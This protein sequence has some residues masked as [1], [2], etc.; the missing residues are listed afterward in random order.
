MT[1]S[2]APLC[3]GEVPSYIRGRRVRGY[4]ARHL[5]LSLPTNLPAPVVTMTPGRP[6]FRDINGWQ[7]S[8][9]VWNRQPK[10]FPRGWNAL[11]VDDPTGWRQTYLANWQAKRRA[12]GL[13]HEVTDPI[14]SANHPQRKK[15]A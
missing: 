10:R 3:W 4:I 11:A 5:Q 6:V 15:T 12:L 9:E 14:W 13:P 8:P 2:S 7:V 1:F